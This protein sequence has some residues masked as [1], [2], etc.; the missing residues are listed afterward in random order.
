MTSPSAVDSLVQF[1]EDNWIW[2]FIFFGSAIGAAF[3]W[4][5]EFLMAALP[6]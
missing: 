2:I 3:T 1:V 6:G 5:G 4:A